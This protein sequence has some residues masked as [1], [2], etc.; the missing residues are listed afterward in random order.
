MKKLIETNTHFKRLQQ[1]S[2]LPPS[3]PHPTTS[4]KKN[5]AV[6]VVVLVCVCV[7]VACLYISFDCFCFHFF[8]LFLFFPL[9]WVSDFFHIRSDTQAVFFLVLFVVVGV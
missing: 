6:V 7:C 8:S 4:P 5:V 9:F 2:S 3:L 1:T